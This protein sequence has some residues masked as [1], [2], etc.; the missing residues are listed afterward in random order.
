LHGVLVSCSIVLSFRASEHILHVH[1]L[2]WTAM[3]LHHFAPHRGN[4]RERTEHP[5]LFRA[6]PR[7]AEEGCVARCQLTRRSR[8]R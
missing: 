8:R 7:Y 4:Q 2:S 3:A 6:L 5:S 1:R